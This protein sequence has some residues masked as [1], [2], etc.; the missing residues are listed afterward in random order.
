M[1]TSLLLAGVII[2]T[3][4]AAALAALMILSALPRRRAAR[5]TIAML[6]APSEPT[7]F[8]FEDR[9]LVDATA[10]ARALLDAVQGSG[11]DWDRLAGFLAQRIARFDAAMD[12]LADRGEVELGGSDDHALRL[13]AEHLGT[14]VRLT[15][16]DPAAEGQGIVVDTLSQRAQDEE[17]AQLREITGSAPVLVWRQNG[18]DMVTWANH[19]YLCAATG[20]AEDD[21]ADLTWP[22]P[23]LF[24]LG[25]DPSIAGS[26]RRLCA[27]LSGSGAGRW[28]ECHTRPAGNGTLHYAVPA[29]AVV[30]AETALREFIQTL[31]KTFAHL[32][33][34]LAIFDR[35]RQ[36]ALFNPA[37]IDLS[38]LGAEFLSA[39]PTLFAFLDRLREA[40]VIPEPKDYHSWRQQMSELEKAASAGFFE[41]TWSLASG[42]TYRVT[43]RPHPDGA[44]AFLIE[45]I[46]A[47]MSLTRRFRSELELGQE[48]VDAI[49][50]AIA[51]FSPAGDLTLSN[52]AY[53]R[54]WGIDPGAT[55]GRI[56]IVDSCR[57]WQSMTRPD[58]AWGDARDFV[59]DI[60]ERAEWTAQ[61]QRPD[62]DALHC[63]FVPLSGGATLVGFS[64]AA[65][66]RLSVRRSRRPRDEAALPAAVGALPA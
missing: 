18:E 63:R 8:L 12:G 64:A 22:L 42:Q 25:R 50:E 29:D 60:G 37:L 17:L 9:E 38:T 1:I 55:L 51:V 54:L 13:R 35:K 49:D 56:T 62:G 10:P 21:P 40:R 59:G 33:I 3:S 52:A 34:G 14:H 57:L 61:V 27:N 6:A 32:P 65:T 31:S 2:V 5:P 4:V 36:L 39:R 15:V 45:D 24:D 43:G 53:A 41:E 58:P 16:T 11:S 28:Y 30:K 20:C 44:V 26:P 7:I 23:R 19:A 66:E 48:V 47:E 46:S